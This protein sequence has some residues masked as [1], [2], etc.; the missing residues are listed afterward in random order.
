MSEIVRDDK[1]RFLPGQTMPAGPGRPPRATERD[2][3]AALVDEMSMERWRKIV[4]KA[5]TDAEKGNGFARQWLA[6]YVIGK[7]PQILDIRAVDA[8][9]MAEVLKQLDAVGM[10]PSELFNNLLVE[11]NSMSEGDHE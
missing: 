6:E 2:Y 7:P 8:K 4:R 1:G 11:L 10:T 5:I 9:L 3:L